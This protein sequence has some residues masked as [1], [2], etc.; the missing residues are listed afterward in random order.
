V[1]AV[2]IRDGRLVAAGRLRIPL[3]ATFP[4][5]AAQRAYDRLAAGAKLGKVVLTAG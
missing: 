4:L 1:R 5:E 3:E 2:T